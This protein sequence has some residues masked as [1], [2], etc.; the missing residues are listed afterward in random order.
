VTA[1]QLYLM[2]AVLTVAA[3][4]LYMIMPTMI[5]GAQRIRRA[6][7]IVALGGVVGALILATRWID[8]AFDGRFFFFIFAGLALAAA[9]RVIS[10]PNPVYCAL[11]FIL[12]VLAVTGL[13][14]LASA[15]F[16]GIALVIV[17]AGAILVTYVFVIMLAQQQGVSLYDRAAR[18]PLAAVVL[19]FVLV[20]AVTRGMIG[21][22]PIASNLLAQKKPT[23]ARTVA[24]TPAVE[25]APAAALVESNT[26]G[27]GRE[28]MTT[29]VVAVEVAGVLLLVAM[30]GAI[31]IAQKRLDPASLTP[32]EKQERER[33]ENL[34]EPGRKALPF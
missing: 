17:Y 1:G 30:V 4:G 8:P 14:I 29:Y 16:L 21:T 34:H 19:G 20:A 3:A 27:V 7:L 31:A 6:G 12:V 13:C 25:T 22:D 28:L 26:R 32:F 11:Y 5:S 10:H 18:E 15:E 2:Y 33:D 9:A 23:V 24:E